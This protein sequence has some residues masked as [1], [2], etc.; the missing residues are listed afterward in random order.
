M[1]ARLRLTLLMSAL[2]IVTG[3]ILLILN[4]TLVRYRISGPTR[5]P[6]V[7]MTRGEPADVMFTWSIK[8]TSAAPAAYEPFEK[9]I[10]IPSPEL[11]TK[12]QDFEEEI[13]SASLRELVLQSSV[14]LGMMGIIAVWLSWVI[15]GHV[16]EPVKGITAVARR[17]SEQ[18]L[19]ERI[20][21]RGPQDE[22]KELADTFD[23]MLDRLEQA[24]QSERRFA[25]NVS[26]ELRTPLTI[27]R[28]EVDV[29]LA[30][31]HA[32]NEELRAMGATIGSAIERSERLIDGLL[33]LA[34]S[35]QIIERREQIE[36]TYTVE[37]ALA[38]I[39][40]EACRRNLQFETDLAEI[41]LQ[42]NGPLLERLV[43]NLIE[44]AV[45]YNHQSGWVRITTAA[46]PTHA[47]LCVENSGP[48]IPAGA[49]AGLFE[50]FR[51][52]RAER[53]ETGCG[54]GLGLSIVRAIA[55]THQGHVEAFARAQGGL[56]VVVTLPVASGS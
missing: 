46:T 19:H 29:T 56:Q 22:L 18:R 40:P 35:Q 5:M 50:P 33:T 17:L 26:H 42:G 13:I 7:A 36:L 2:F 30:D 55:Q 37:E 11:A 16:L 32:S 49:V 14:A 20:A 48:T 8:S 25:A 34:R 4:Y 27:M 41:C 15:A 10:A 28:T 44:N 43:A 51:R 47:Q 6:V 53:T 1:T 24:F 3:A 12:L 31:P 52:L 9:A 23:R 54:A 38:G 21:L 39:A 45:R